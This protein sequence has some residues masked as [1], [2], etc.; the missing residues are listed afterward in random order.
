[1]RWLHKGEFYYDRKRF[2]PNR[3]IHTASATPSELNIS[4][5][6]YV[7][8]LEDDRIMEKDGVSCDDP[9]TWPYSRLF[10]LYIF[11]QEYEVELFRFDIQD[12]IHIKLIEEHSLPK[13]A[14]LADVVKKLSDQDTLRYLLAHWFA[15]TNRNCRVEHIPEAIQEFSVLPS[16]FIFLSLLLRDARYVADSCP[17]CGQGN[18][19]GKCNVSDLLKDDTMMSYLKPPWSYHHH[20][21]WDKS[22]KGARCYWR[23]MS[24]M[25]RIS[26]IDF[27]NRDEACGNVNDMVAPA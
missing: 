12:I 4:A 13:T 11:A 21:A 23:W 19:D 10:E 20:D 16:S 24:K 5:E 3:C 15:W 17:I 1:M 18:T 6:G 7:T 22:G 27:I 9:V 14:E 2:G 8:E 26:T 25:H